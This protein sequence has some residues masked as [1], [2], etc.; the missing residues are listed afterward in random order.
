MRT[1][2]IRFKVDLANRREVR[3]G[4]TDVFGYSVG[5]VCAVPADLADKWIASG[6]AELVNPSRNVDVERAT[7]EPRSEKA[8]TIKRRRA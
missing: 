1:R 5:D 7:R 8:T 3:P 4:V 6:F 2:T